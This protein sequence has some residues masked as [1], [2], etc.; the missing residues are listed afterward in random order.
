MRTVL[1]EF[2]HR[3]STSN[4]A[5][6][7]PTTG[8][9]HPPGQSRLAS[10]RRRPGTLTP[11][12]TTISRRRNR[13]PPPP[14][15]PRQ[16]IQRDLRLENLNRTRPTV[17]SNQPTTSTATATRTNSM[18]SALF[19]LLPP[20]QRER[21]PR[22]L[23]R[24]E[25]T[26]D[27]GVRISEMP[28]SANVEVPSPIRQI[29]TAEQSTTPDNNN[30]IFADIDD[31][32]DYVSG[33]DDDEETNSEFLRRVEYRGPPDRDLISLVGTVTRSGIV[34]PNTAADDGHGDDITHIPSP[35]SVFRKARLL[36][37]SQLGAQVDVPA[38][39]P[40]TCSDMFVCKICYV[41][42]IK[43]VGICGHSICLC[44]YKK[45]LDRPSQRERETIELGNDPS[46][47][48]VDDATEGYD[49]HE[50]QLDT[51]CYFC[52]QDFFVQPSEEHED[53]GVRIILT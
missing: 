6:Q 11:T 42:C 28:F 7:R 23:L 17:S 44:C 43:I 38:G 15:R 45:L 53:D 21:R 50:L 29:M 51:N 27:G 31:D 33:T 3:Y 46:M 2:L 1:P 34:S 37:V 22:G 9:I 35:E 26:P 5:E 32:D 16:V 8:G 24:F 52:R 20:L 25:E 36:R 14:L 40:H 18:I 13:P 39:A 49:E 10:I 4:N 30:N 12:T 19:Q 47:V 41:N 48:P